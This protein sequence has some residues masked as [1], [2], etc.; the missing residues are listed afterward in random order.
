MRQVILTKQVR[1]GRIIW[2]SS[3][4]PQEERALLI[5]I[6]IIQRNSEVIKQVDLVHR[7]I[8][9]GLMENAKEAPVFEMVVDIIFVF[10]HQN[11]LP[12]P[13]ELRYLINFIQDMDA[14]LETSELNFAFKNLL[15]ISPKKI[16]IL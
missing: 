16:K 9:L 15:L 6:L 12:P 8:L 2:V 3:A 14:E 4:I 7:G 13:E 11:F 5:F 10:F 1:S